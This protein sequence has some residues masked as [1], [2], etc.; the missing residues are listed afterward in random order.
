[1]R[2]IQEASR[3]QI[4]TLQFSTI[5]SG[6]RG[7]KESTVSYSTSPA[8][9]F[10]GGQGAPSS[11]PPSVVFVLCSDDFY[12]AQVGSPKNDDGDS[13]RIVTQTGPKDHPIGFQQ[14]GVFSWVPF[15]AGQ[16]KPPTTTTWILDLPLK[17]TKHIQG[18]KHRQAPG[19]LPPPPHPPGS[20]S[21]GLGAAAATSSG[22]IGQALLEKVN[23]VS[24]KLEAGLKVPNRWLVG[25]FF[26]GFGPKPENGGPLFWCTFKKRPEKGQRQMSRGHLT[27]LPES[28]QTSTMRQ[29]SRGYL[30]PQNWKLEAGSSS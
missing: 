27:G 29:T 10:R 11:I 6:L 13:S 26:P 21:Q 18:R 8:C 7:I 30:V 20:P 4:K 19:K 12:W 14:G 25:S 16:T 28:A 9:A 3:E 15:Q 23:A 22:P 2:V 5:L 24:G 1:M 17:H